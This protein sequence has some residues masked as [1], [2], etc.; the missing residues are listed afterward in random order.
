MVI[1]SF[2][3]LSKFVEPHIHALYLPCAHP[4]YML[5]WVYVLYVCVFEVGK[6]DT[7]PVLHVS[8][9]SQ[10]L[11]VVFG[12]KVQRRSEG[13]ASGVWQVRPR[14][15]STGSPTICQIRHQL[16]SLHIGHLHI[17]VDSGVYIKSAYNNDHNRSTS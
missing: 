1:G 5:V 12:C 6:V 7:H 17:T 16:V 15:V 2:V 14:L 10:C 8:Q 13:R 9:Q 3:G 11:I 4:V